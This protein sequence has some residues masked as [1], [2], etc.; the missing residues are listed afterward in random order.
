M[1]FR[2]ALLQALRTLRT[3]RLRSFLTMFG[4]V[5]GTA[6]VVFL[7][8]WGLGVQEMLEAG[9]SRAGKNVVMAWP[10][11][12][13]EDFTPAGDRRELWFTRADVEAVR[14]QVRLA[15]A[16]TAE[17]RF[18][19]SVG[20]GQTT[21]ST[22]VRGVEPAGLEM[23]GTALAAGRP[24]LPGDLAGRR[25]VAVLGEAARRRLLGP[26]GGGVG[27]TIEIRGHSFRVVGVL[28][29]VGTQLWRDNGA[30]IDEQVWIPLTTLFVLDPRP[31]RDD[32]VVDRIL[33]RVARRQDYDALKTDVRRVLAERLRFA[34]TDEE[35]VSL[36][37]PID[38][39]RK[40]PIDQTTGLLLILGGATLLIGGIGILTMMLDAVQ[41]RRQEIGVRLAVGARRR[42]VLGQ[43]FLET[44]LITT[45]GGVIG[46]ALGIGGALGLAQLEVP[47]LIPVPIL[48]GWIVVLAIAV[49]TVV[50][51]AAGLVPAW[52]A[53]RVDP[54]VT[55]RAE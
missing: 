47:D 53:A 9:L 25:R 55:L 14:R 48:R 40:L 19:S 32:D 21:L 22:D 23:H 17:S 44:F 29:R 36:A 38:L 30:E 50:G 13:G 33:M 51:L 43:F 2:E 28:A 26:S 35:A 39:L 6:S 11:K 27:A 1:H 12:I 42:D 3:E 54:S 4:V 52:R 10:G 46:L 31:G 49:M 34:P 37:S 24:I 16:V 41:E 20:H 15:V 45:I 18:W 7:M 5:W 8:S